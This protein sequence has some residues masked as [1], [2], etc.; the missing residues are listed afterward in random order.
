MKPIWVLTTVLASF[1]LTIFLSNFEADRQKILYKPFQHVVS[2]FQSKL[3]L[4]GSEESETGFKFKTLSREHE[5]I[6]IVVGFG[7]F[8][9]NSAHL[10]N[11]KLPGLE[12]P[13]INP[14]E[15]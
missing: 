7:S 15:I 11:E 10:E 5:E 8:S 12:T 3:P 1:W 13:T 14:R 4:C 6:Q 9:S 2:D